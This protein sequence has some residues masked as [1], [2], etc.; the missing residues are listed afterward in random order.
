MAK[1][2]TTDL[3]RIMPATLVSPRD[4]KEALLDPSLTAVAKGAVEGAWSIEPAEDDW[5]PSEAFLLDEGEVKHILPGTAIRV[6]SGGGWLHCEFP[7]AGG[8]Y[9]PAVW[10]PAEAASDHDL[11]AEAREDHAKWKIGMP[12]AL[13]VL[14]PNV[15]G[16]PLW[17]SRIQDRLM[18]PEVTDK[19]AVMAEMMFFADAVPYSVFG[20]FGLAAA[21]GIGAE[22]LR[23][24][25]H[26][27]TIE[28]VN[29]RVSAVLRMPRSALKALGGSRPHLRL[30]APDRPMDDLDQAIADSLDSYHAQRA[31]LMSKKV[32]GSPLLEHTYTMLEEI[33]LR[34]EADRSALREDSLRQTYLELIQRAEA[35]VTLVLEKK[36]AA[37]AEA[38]VGDMTALLQQMDR[39]K[40]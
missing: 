40:A 24:R 36:D 6:Q 25:L 10:A 31:R 5:A 37:T 33:S 9:G 11:L 12:V 16:M 27:L 2:K 28:S 7:Q 26:P 30:V 1:P 4:R 18:D 15:V 34:M 14:L 35:D 3:A 20:G 17:L 29:Q 13:F 38:L 19:A 32:T 21:A 39:H 22:I 23:R 8:L